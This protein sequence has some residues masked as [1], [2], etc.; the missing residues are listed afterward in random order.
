[1]P[2]QIIKNNGALQKI[3]QT[4]MARA[5]QAQHSVS[6]TNSAISA[7]SNELAACN[8]LRQEMQVGFSTPLPPFP[9]QCEKR[10]GV[11]GEN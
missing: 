9:T 3:A 5:E 8:Q 10:S 1:V 7:L 2:W 11:H 6:A 4:A